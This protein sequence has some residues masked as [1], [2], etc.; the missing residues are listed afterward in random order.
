MGYKKRLEK[1]TDAVEGILGSSVK[2]KK[3]KKIKALQRFIEKMESKRGEIS[4]EL[5]QEGLA[6]KLR[7][8]KAR[9][10]ETLDKQ[11]RKANKVLA[12]MK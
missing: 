6:P 1:I 2:A 3:L 5:E 9:H 11:I 4:Q 10:L 7:D 12:E 8:E